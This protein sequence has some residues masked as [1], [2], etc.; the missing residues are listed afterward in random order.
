MLPYMFCNEQAANRF[1]RLKNIE[2]DTHER[3]DVFRI[4]FIIHEPFKKLNRKRNL[5]DKR[6]ILWGVGF[7]Q[8]TLLKYQSCHIYKINFLKLA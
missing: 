2:F 6:K 8:F 4:I 5:F 7:G 3:R 1:V